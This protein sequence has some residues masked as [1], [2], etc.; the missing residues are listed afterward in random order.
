[1]RQLDVKNAFLNGTL[2][3][4]VYMEQPPGYIDPRFPNHVCQLK[5]A[6]YGLKQAPRAWFQS[7]STFL[8]HLGFSCSRAD[9]SLF[10]YHQKSN[11]IYLL[12]YVDDI[13]ITGN[14]SSLLDSFTCKLNS[15]FATKDLGSL[16]YFLG[17]EATPTSDGFFISQLKYARD[18]LSRAQLLD[19]KPVHIPMVVS[20]HLSADGSLFSD[21]T[22]YRSL[23]GALQYLTITQPDIAHAVNSVSQFLHAPTEDHFLAVKRILRYVKGTIH[24]GLTF[25]PSSSPGALVAYSDT[26]WADCPDTRRS[27]SGYSIYLGDNLVSWSA[28]KQPTVFRSSCESEYCAL[29]FTVAELIWLTHLL[30]DLQVP[31]SQQPLLLCDNKSAFFLAPIRFHTNGLSMLNWT[32]TFSVNLLWLANFAPNMSHLIYRLLIFLLRVFLVLYLSSF[33]PTSTSDPIRRFACG[34]C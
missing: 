3:D 31:M 25:R 12:L 16:S 29:A 23:V 15:E 22:L 2:T 19:S 26:D 14:N 13:I 32:I 28:K 1:L 10:I 18:I 4:Q 5:K 24:F 20:Q 21:P 34:G 11:I 6:L 8:I 9:T 30:R 17:L 33:D 27:T 7:F